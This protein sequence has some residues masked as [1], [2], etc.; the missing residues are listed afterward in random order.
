MVFHSATQVAK[1]IGLHHLDYTDTSISTEERH[2]QMG[3]LSCLRILDKGVLWTAGWPVCLPVSDATIQ[4]TLDSSL[5]EVEKFFVSRLRLSQIEEEV[6]VELFSNESRRQ[7]PL[8]RLQSVSKL[9]KTLQSWWSEHGAATEGVA[10]DDFPSCTNAELNYC[11]HVI[12]LMVNWPVE[13]NQNAYS[14]FVEDARASLRLI[15][16][17]WEA[18]SEIGHYGSLQR[19]TSTS[20]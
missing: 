17:L 11:F 16:R 9:N 8:Q 3:V 14:R 13:K 10:F 12:R 18:T 20:F 19:Y 5:C 7:S 6:F 4:L 15:L 1:S 2:E